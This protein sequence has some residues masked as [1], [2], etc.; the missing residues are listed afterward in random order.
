MPE[1][2]A[3]GR[4]SANPTIAACSQCHQTNGKGRPEN[5]GVAGLPYNYIVQQLTEFRNGN[6]KTSD[7]RKTNTA[8]MSGFARAMTDE[9]IKQAAT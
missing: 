2:V 7:S 3:H 5:A 9:E 8:T 4:Q 1:I 6:R